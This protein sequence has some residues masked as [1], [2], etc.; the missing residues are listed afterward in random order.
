MTQKGTNENFPK[1][2]S[3]KRTIKIKDQEKFYVKQILADLV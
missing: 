3:K 1:N 2:L